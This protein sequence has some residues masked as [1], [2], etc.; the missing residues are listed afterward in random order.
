MGGSRGL[1]LVRGDQITETRSDATV[2]A[3]YSSWARC[4]LAEFIFIALLT[5]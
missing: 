1:V 3:A 4:A 2:E 5:A